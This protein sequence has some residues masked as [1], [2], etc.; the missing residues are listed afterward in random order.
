VRFAV[1]TC[2][3]L[4]AVAAVVA[5]RERRPVVDA[6]LGRVTGTILF[7]GKPPSSRTWTDD[8]GYAKCASS[9]PREEPLIIASNGGVANFFVGI[10]SSGANE[11]TPQVLTIVLSGC[12][13]DRK[14]SVFSPGTRISFVNNDRSPHVIRA[15]RGAQSYFTYPLVY[16]S[17]TREVVPNLMGEH[18]LSVMCVVHPWERTYLVESTDRQFEVTGPGGGFHFEGVTPGDH[19]IEVWHPELGWRVIPVNVRGGET[20][21]VQVI[22]GEQDLRE[23][24]PSRPAHQ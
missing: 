17:W 24:F 18:T 5:V 4:L 7:Q 13:F 2:L 19:E 21:S 9:I 10:R 22:F 14:L 6:S 20:A 8:S 15:F 16:G 11:S 3:A 12:N 23:P 1:I